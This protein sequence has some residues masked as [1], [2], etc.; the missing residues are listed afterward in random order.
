MKKWCDNCEHFDVRNELFG[1]CEECYV[2]EDGIPSCFIPD[3]TAQKEDMVNSPKHYKNKY[4][5]IDVMIDTFGREAV[6]HFCL[7][8]SFKYLYRCTHKGKQT[9]DIKKSKWY[10]EKYIELTEGKN[11][12]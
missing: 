7:L 4:E 8:N 12:N 11:E 10:L 2:A 3:K 6:Q 9:E 1:K 5:C